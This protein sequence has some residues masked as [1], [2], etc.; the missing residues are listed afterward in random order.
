MAFNKSTLLLSFALM[1]FLVGTIG[2]YA[3]NWLITYSGVWILYIPL[4][5]FSPAFMSGIAGSLLS[6][7][8]VYIAAHFMVEK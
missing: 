6:I 3:L 8:F 1:G 5:I 7:V 2:Y 4:P